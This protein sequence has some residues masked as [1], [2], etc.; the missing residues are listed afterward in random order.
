MCELGLTRTFQNA[1]P[2]RS[3]TVMRNVMV[4]GITRGQSIRHAQQVAE[5][6][7]HDVGLWHR[8]DER[9]DILPLGQLKRLE[10]AR[11]LAT[12]PKALLLD[13]VTAGLSPGE[14]DDVVDFIL[15]LPTRGIT[16]IMIEH[17]MR[18][19]LSA[20][21][22]LIVLNFGHVI[23]EGNGK[24]VAEHPDVIR[25]YLGDSSLPSDLTSA[26]SSA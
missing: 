6:A 7:L 1:K 10:I 12:E 19:A 13:E 2:F 21:Q 24:A 26:S 11:C 16:L 8:R 22:R 17:N 23:A 18:V 15:T 20:C 4:G 5:Q 25:A 3:L 14:V 9:A